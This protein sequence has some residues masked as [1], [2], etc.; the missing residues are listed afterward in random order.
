M[1]TTR[2]FTATVYLVDDGATALH[3]HPKLGIRLPPGGH[4]ERDELPHEAGLRETR[5][6]TGLDAELLGG[7]PNVEAP[8]GRALP[9]P[10]YQML[11]DIDVHSDGG[12]SHQ[13]IDHV[14][15]ARVG[16]RDIAPEGTNEPGPD[17]WNWYT[18]DELE[19]SDIDADTV[20]MGCEAICAADST[21]ARSRDDP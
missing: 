4:V 19:A 15:F 14:Y 17:A 9:H 1:E 16:S 13:H 8:D 18:P 3:D 6:E 21:G 12:V 11:Y 10:R 5:E 2:H 7:V 20:R